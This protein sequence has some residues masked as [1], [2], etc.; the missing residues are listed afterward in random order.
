MAS[1]FNS[2]QFGKSDWSNNTSIKQNSIIHWTVDENSP[3]NQFMSLF[4]YTYDDWTCSYVTSS[5][6]HTPMDKLSKVSAYF[7]NGPDGMS[8]N[9]A[10]IVDDRHYRLINSGVLEDHEATLDSNIYDGSAV[11]SWG[12][13]LVRNPSIGSPTVN[14]PSSISILAL[15]L[16]V[17][18]LRRRKASKL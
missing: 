2:F 8:L 1:V 11:G 17:L 12:V 5:F 9:L 6:C 10:T 15:G 16:A 18:G 7:G 4:G 14:L 13:A 3:H